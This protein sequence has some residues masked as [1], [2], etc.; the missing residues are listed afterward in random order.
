MYSSVLLASFNSDVLT[1]TIITHAYGHKVIVRRMYSMCSDQVKTIIMF[2][3]LKYIDVLYS[4]Y[5]IPLKSAFKTKCILE[6]SWFVTTVIA[7][8]F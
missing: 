2:I 4:M 8:A 1:G 6:Y 5:I 3:S 7:K